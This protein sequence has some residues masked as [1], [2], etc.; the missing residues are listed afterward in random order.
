[1][2]CARRSLSTTL[3]LYRILESGSFATDCTIRTQT[4][5]FKVHQF[6][7]NQA[8]TDCDVH[9]YDEGED[10]DG[11]DLHIDVHGDIAEDIIRH[12]YGV[13]VPILQPAAGSKPTTQRCKK[14]LELAINAGDVS[15][16]LVCLVIWLTNK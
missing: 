16:S 3:T 14:V 7:I 2:L 10:G 11:S 15:S 13:Q 4:K 1:M 5:T 9:E 12:S 6:V 8:L